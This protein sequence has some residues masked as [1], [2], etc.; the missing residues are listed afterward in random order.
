M[1]AREAV[2]ASAPEM[3]NMSSCS[4]VRGKG[5]GGVRDGRDRGLTKSDSARISVLCYRH[6]DTKPR[7]GIKKKNDLKRDSMRYHNMYSHTY[8]HILIQNTHAR[9]HAHTPTQSHTQGHA[10]NFI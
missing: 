9:T 3:H 10:L 8:T 6:S 4:F 7:R 1:E 2:T 5:V